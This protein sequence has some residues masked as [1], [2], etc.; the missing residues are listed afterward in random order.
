M[1]EENCDGILKLAVFSIGTTQIP[2]LHSLTDVHYQ[3]E[4][5]RSP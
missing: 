2:E 3:D 4:A 1:T 5:V